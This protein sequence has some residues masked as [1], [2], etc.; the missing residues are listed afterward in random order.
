MTR[1]SLIRCVA[2]LGSD[3][4]DI[5]PDVPVSSLYALESR[6]DL[7]AAVEINPGHNE[8]QAERI[9]SYDDGNTWTGPWMRRGRKPFQ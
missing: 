8:F 6:I 1:G 9:V 3:R 7:Y 4:F 5:V 2:H